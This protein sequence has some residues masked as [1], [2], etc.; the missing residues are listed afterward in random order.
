MINIII[1]T[2]QNEEIFLPGSCKVETKDSTTLAKVLNNVVIAFVKYLS[3]VKA[4]ITDNVYKNITIV[5]NIT[6]TLNK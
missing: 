6:N 4:I 3:R 5:T 1:K 2:Y